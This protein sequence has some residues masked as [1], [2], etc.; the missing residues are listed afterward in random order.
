MC[1]GSVCGDD[2]VVFFFYVAFACSGTGFV[3][4]LALSFSVAAS[5]LWNQDACMQNLWASF[6]VQCYHTVSNS[7][8][9][10][11]RYDGVFSML[12]S[13]PCNLMAC[14]T[15]CLGMPSCVC[16]CVRA[17][18]RVYDYSSWTICVSR[19]CDKSYWEGRLKRHELDI[20]AACVARKR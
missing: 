19:V 17:C 3:S 9:D 14:A 8:W 15:A 2:S 11:R 20:C 6:H 13:G 5:R 18:V 12:G 10:S 1:R 16:A 7:K 4:L